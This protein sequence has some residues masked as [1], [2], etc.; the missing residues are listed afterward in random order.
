M[1]VG[2]LIA[3]AAY[4]GLVDRPHGAVV[5]AVT[6]LGAILANALK[7]AVRSGLDR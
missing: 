4:Y 2:G 1:V 6:A 7:Q 5:A 3:A